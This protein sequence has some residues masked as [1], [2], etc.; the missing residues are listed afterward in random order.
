MLIDRVLTSSGMYITKHEVVDGISEAHHRGSLSYVY[1]LFFITIG[2]LFCRVQLLC[3][4]EA[5]D[6]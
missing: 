4:V 6:H 2:L 3:L 1:L 5:V